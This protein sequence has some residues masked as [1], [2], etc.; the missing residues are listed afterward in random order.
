MSI[1][2]CDI[3]GLTSHEFV[4]N[5]Q[6]QG[7][8]ADAALQTY[9]AIFRNGRID[10]SDVSLPPVNI[11]KREREEETI[12]FTLEHEDNLE[13]EAVILPQHGRTGKK[14]NT[15]CVSSQIGCALGCT[16]C[17][18]GQMCRLKNLSASEIVAQWFAATFEFSTTITNV[19]FMGMGEPMDNLDAVIQAIRV[20]V[21]HNGPNIP[22]S[23]ISVSTAGLIAGIDRL[24]ELVREPGFGR[25]GLA[26]SLNAPND[27]I[28]QQLMPI[29]RSHSMEELREALVRWPLRK[30]AHILI[31]YVLI[32]S[33]NDAP[34]HAQQLCN[35][36]KPLNCM[37][38]VI[39][40]NPGSTNSRSSLIYEAPSENQANRF[41]NH[42]RDLGVKVQRRQSRG[43]SIKAACGQLGNTNIR[44]ITDSRRS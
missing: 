22:A 35:Y 39:P 33:V 26:I 12:K 3:L 37:V 36:L 4:S 21:D 14:R 16:F 20:L 24:A 7:V 30:P 15:L 43:Q 18:T 6:I 41:I 44:R 28:R 40:F 5:R 31:E 13:C 25:L 34:D 23:K 8:N 10:I 32:P 38:N 42:L 29:A 27:S 9:R 17:E 19:V 1:S 2:D 11:S